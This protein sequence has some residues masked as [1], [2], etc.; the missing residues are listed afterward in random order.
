[1]RADRVEPRFERAAPAAQGLRAI[2]A[3]CQ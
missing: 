2:A 1:L 3:E